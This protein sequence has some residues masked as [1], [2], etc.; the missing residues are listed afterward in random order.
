MTQ[1]TETITLP[2]KTFSCSGGQGPLGHPQVYLTFTDKGKIDCPYCGRHFI[3]EA[4]VNHSAQ[5][6]GVKIIP[7]QH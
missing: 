7:S 1:K 3:F 6:D 2:D 5:M 4:H